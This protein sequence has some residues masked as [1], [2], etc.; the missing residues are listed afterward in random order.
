MT[1][2]SGADD[3]WLADFAALVHG[4]IARQPRSAGVGAL[5]SS[6]NMARNAEEELAVD[7]ACHVVEYFG[8][9]LSRAQYASLA[10]L[11]DR[12]GQADSLEEIDLKP[13]VAD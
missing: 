8:M 3:A 9:S 11:A 12:V 5:L 4:L 1:V 13:F 2:T 10:E 7:D 6:L